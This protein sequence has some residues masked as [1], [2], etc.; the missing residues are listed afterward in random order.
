MKKLASFVAMCF[1]F[2][3]LV[4]PITQGNLVPS[5]KVKKAAIALKL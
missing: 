4:V 2:M 5:T 3:I 1:L